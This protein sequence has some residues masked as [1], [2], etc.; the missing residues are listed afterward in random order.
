MSNSHPAK[1]SRRTVCELTTESNQ[2]TVAFRSS[3]LTSIKGF[4]ALIFCVT[5]NY[6][7]AYV[8]ERVCDVLGFFGSILKK[9]WIPDKE[10]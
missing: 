1:I 9:L 5:S 10:Y 6:N 3:P 4:L 8:R 7:A 2:L